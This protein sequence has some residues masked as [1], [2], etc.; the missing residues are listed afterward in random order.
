MYEICV[1]NMGF[2][3][4]WTSEGDAKIIANKKLFFKKSI[5]DF[6]VYIV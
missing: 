6:D 5:M 3:I 1:L 2:V 4:R